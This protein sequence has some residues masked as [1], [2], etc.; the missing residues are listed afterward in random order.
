ME[1]IT[2]REGRDFLFFAMK[3]EGRWEVRFLGTSLEVNKEAVRDQLRSVGSQLAQYASR[4]RASI[5]KARVYLQE[6]LLQGKNRQGGGY[7]IK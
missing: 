6:Q 4:G 5:E 3:E 2:L 1:R 7:P